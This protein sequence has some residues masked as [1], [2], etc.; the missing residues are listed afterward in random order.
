MDFI[1]Y[2]CNRISQIQGHLDKGEAYCG[3]SAGLIKEVLTAQEVVQRL[4]KGYE[5]IVELLPQSL[6]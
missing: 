1:G 3:A 5:K 4:V 6:R 2:R